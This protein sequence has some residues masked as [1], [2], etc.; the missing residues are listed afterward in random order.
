MRGSG[1]FNSDKPL[2]SEDHHIA[3]ALERYRMISLSPSRTLRR[4]V[5]S[6]F[7]AT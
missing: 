6:I 5:S 4:S 7:D 2:E 3:S 1:D